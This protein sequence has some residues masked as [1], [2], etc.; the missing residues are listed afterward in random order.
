MKNCTAETCTA[1]TC[2]AGPRK[3]AARR[4]MALAAVLATAVVAAPVAHAQ[5]RPDSARMQCAQVWP[6]V[7]S[8]GVVIL[9]TGP[10]V[11]DRFVADGRFCA[12]TQRTDVAFVRSAD[13]ANCFAGYICRERTPLAPNR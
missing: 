7:Q 4:A 3:A 9:G 5:Q 10:Y 8:R 12:V 11:Y 1:E 6:F 13:A 2:V